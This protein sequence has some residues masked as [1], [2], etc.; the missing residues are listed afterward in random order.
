MLVWRNWWIIK[1]IFLNLQG[2]SNLVNCLLYNAREEQAVRLLILSLLL[3]LIGF[4][5]EEFG[6]TSR[7]YFQ[8]HQYNFFTLFTC[9]LNQFSLYRLVAD[10]NSP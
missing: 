10:E 7:E 5:H 9:L 6:S 1:T 3:P 4:F 2:F 8:A